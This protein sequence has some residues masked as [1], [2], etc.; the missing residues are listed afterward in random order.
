MQDGLLIG[1]YEKNSRI[2]KYQ[3]VKRYTQI[4]H[5]F[6]CDLRTRHENLLVLINI[7]LDFSWRL[8]YLCFEL[9]YLRAKSQWH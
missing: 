4:N 9:L 3:C 6:H 8:V 5:K 1:Y 7:C 2:R